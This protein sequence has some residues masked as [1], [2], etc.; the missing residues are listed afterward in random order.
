[1]HHPDPQLRAVRSCH[2]EGRSQSLLPT[3]GE[4]WCCHVSCNAWRKLLRKAW[5]QSLSVVR[6]CINC[7]QDINLPAPVAGSASAVR[8]LH[9]NSRV[10][11]ARP[12]T[13]YA[14]WA[15]DIMTPT[16]ARVVPR[17]RVTGREDRTPPP[18]HP[19]MHRVSAYAATY[20]RALLRL[21]GARAR[22][23]RRPTW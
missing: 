21:D 2:E 6:L 19:Y 20:S 18:E 10:T 23:T 5:R 12:L 9:S 1:V 4:A 17:R 8:R 15:A 7:G 3:Q 13:L 14:A 16:M 11:E 22:Q